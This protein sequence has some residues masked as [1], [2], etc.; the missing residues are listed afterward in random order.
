MMLLVACSGCALGTGPVVGYGTKK[1]L[2]AGG[3][4]Y[5]GLTFPQVAFEVGG[6]K[7]GT[8][9]QV[10]FEIEA[11][12]VR[13]MSGNAGIPYP[14]GRIGFGYSR[15]NGE[16]DFAFLLGPDI[17]L[18]HNERFCDGAGAFYGGVELRYAGSEWQVVAAPRYE[19]LYDLCLR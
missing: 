19:L 16:G 17:A 8:L 6:T 9:A 3:S 14:G 15:T 7:E 2:Y 1:G 10:R 11:S 13:A 5:A 4:M 18:L 12:K